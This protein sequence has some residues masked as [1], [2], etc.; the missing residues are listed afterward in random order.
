M[1]C[2]RP[3]GNASLDNSLRAELLAPLLELEPSRYEM[4]GNLMHVVL[5]KTACPLC[6]REDSEILF[7]ASNRRDGLPVS[8]SYHKCRNCGTLFLNPTLDEASFSDYDEVYTRDLYCEESQ[9]NLT[10]LDRIFRAFNGT[11]SQGFLHKLPHEIGKGRRMLDVGCSTGEKLRHFAERGYQIFG[12]DMA[13][14]AVRIANSRYGSGFTYGS[15][16]QAGYEEDYFDV[17]RLDNV[18]EHIADPVTTLIEV[19][20]ILKP[21]AHAYIYVPN[22]ESLTV[23]IL[24]DISI[25]SWVPFHVVL[26]SPATLRLALLRAGFSEISIKSHTPGDLLVLTFAQLLGM[27]ERVLAEFPKPVYLSLFILT[28]PI[29]LIMSL[30]PKG[31]ELVAI[32]EKE[33]PRAIA[34]ESP[35]TGP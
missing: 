9:S 6:R 23:K 27:N 11:T 24:R 14:D 19:R 29:S 28:L 25:N 12:L 20:R 13:E 26:Y 31:E 2:E 21:G 5:K 10:I 3:Q 22:G 4:A 30:L 35:Q 34:D 16:S 1:V 15:L 18:L 17:V 33:R 8:S 32:A 7:D